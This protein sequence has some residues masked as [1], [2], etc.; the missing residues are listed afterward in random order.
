VLRKERWSLVQHHLGDGKRHARPDKGEDAAFLAE[1]LDRGRSAWE[2]EDPGTVGFQRD[3]IPARVEH[4]EGAVLEL[5]QC[6]QDRLAQLR[7]RWWFKWMHRV[8]NDPSLAS[9]VRDAN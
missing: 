5:R 8:L 2:L 9:A 3:R 6:R 7:K 4:L 1:P